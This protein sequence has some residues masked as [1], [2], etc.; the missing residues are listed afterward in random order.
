MVIEHINFFHIVY[1]FFAGFISFLTP[2]ILPLLPI[3]IGGAVAKRPWAVLHICAGMIC[4]YTLVGATTGFIRPILGLS[5]DN[6]NVAAGVSILVM[7]VILLLPSLIVPLQISWQVALAPL[8]RLSER[9]S[10]ETASGAFLLGAVLSLAWTPCAGPMLGS[11][12]AMVAAEGGH[13][14]GAFLLAVYGVGA[15][16]PLIFMACISRQNFVNLFKKI[17]LSQNGVRIGLALFQI[18]F[19]LALISGSIIWLEKVLINL[20]PYEVL[21]FLYSI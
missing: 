18:L 12:L 15:T 13:I 16:C 11:A 17:N 20:I 5:P 4:V 9:I 10:V 21:V 2:C 8:I 7:S 19:G 3:V 1:T 14:R 6:Y